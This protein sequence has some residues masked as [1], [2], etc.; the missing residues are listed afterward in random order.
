MKPQG[1]TSRHRRP[2]AHHGFAVLLLA[3]AG[4]LLSAG[5]HRWLPQSWLPAEPAAAPPAPPPNPATDPQGHMR[6]ARDA[7]VRQRFEQAVAMLHA[8]QYEYA[9]IALQR[10]LRLQPR[11]PEAH[12]NLGFALLGLERA[13]D[14]QLAFERAIDQR[15]A[16][17]NAYYGLAT[18]LEWRGELRGALGAMRSYLHLSRADDPYRAKAR[19]ALWEWEQ[20]LAG[21]PAPS[22]RTTAPSIPGTVLARAAGSPLRQTVAAPSAPGQSGQGTSTW[23]EP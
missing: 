17:A 18:A 22:D 4:V 19:A 11:L 3:V 13:A 8:R 21:R 14:A 20:T 16:Q 15:P 10:V 1:A 9:A 12:V 5:A 23:Q 7:E 6:A 2:W